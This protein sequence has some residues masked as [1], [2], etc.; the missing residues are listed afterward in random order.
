MG[1]WLELFSCDQ[2]I[3]ER[4]AS[5]S[6]SKATEDRSPVPHFLKNDRK[7]SNLMSKPNCPTGIK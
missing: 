6:I 2:L 3:T 4:K 1:P 5:F 7:R